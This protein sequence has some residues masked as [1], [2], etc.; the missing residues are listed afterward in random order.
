MQEEHL[1]CGTDDCCQ[2]CDT[3]EGDTMSSMS[4]IIARIEAL[5]KQVKELQE[6]LASK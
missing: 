3:A 6:Q 2:Q 4:E 1:Y 5:E